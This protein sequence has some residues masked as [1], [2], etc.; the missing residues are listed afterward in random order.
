MSKVFL[1]LEAQHVWETL[2]FLTR[3]NADSTGQQMEK[4]MPILGMFPFASLKEQV[5]KEPER[6]FIVDVGSGKGQAMLAIETEC[7][8]FFG[9]SVILQDLPIVINTLKAEDLPGITPT[10]HDIFTPQPVKST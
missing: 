7:P 1:S 4:N 6:P 5:E 8:N 3:N 10:I 2:S 9:A